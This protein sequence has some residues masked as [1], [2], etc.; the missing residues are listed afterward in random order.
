MDWRVIVNHDRYGHGGCYLSR[1]FGI[2][3]CPNMSERVSKYI[4]RSAY[5]HVYTN[6]LLEHCLSCVEFTT[7]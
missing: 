4:L 6:I 2:R 3:I 7:M 5:V 1:E